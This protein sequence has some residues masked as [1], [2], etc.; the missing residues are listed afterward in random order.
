MSICAKLQWKTA[1]KIVEGLRS[2]GTSS[3]RKTSS[4]W[5]TNHIVMVDKKT[6]DMID[7]AIPVESNIKKKEHKRVP[8]TEETTGADVASKKKKRSHWS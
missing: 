2:C 1:T 8:G 4:C 5:P 6:A 3:S 7:V